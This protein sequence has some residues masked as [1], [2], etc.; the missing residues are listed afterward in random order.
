MNGTSTS[1]IAKEH[2]TEHQIEFRDNYDYAVVEDGVREEAK[3]QASASAD[4]LLPTPL[5][6]NFCETRQGNS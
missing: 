1:V 6:S 3:N 2:T 5:S 4:A